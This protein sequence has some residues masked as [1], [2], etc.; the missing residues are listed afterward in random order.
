MNQVTNGL[1]LVH[2][3]PSFLLK[4]IEWSICHVLGY[5]PSF[6]WS[7][8]PLVAD[9]YRSEI[10][11]EGPASAGAQLSTLLA[12]WRSVSFEVTQAAGAGAS[13]SRWLYSPT[14]GIKHR[15]TDDV[16]NYLIGEEELRGALQRAGSNSLELHREMQNLLAG[17]W[18]EALE[19][20]RV[21]SADSPVVWLFRTG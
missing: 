19:P 10:I 20:L 7:R 21:A 1:I 15:A 11:W 6:A 13:A 2:D 18:E 3:S 5:E 17:P 12:G 4:Q 9:H 14:L 16:G 8:Q